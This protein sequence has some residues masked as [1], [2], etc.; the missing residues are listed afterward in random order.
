MKDANTLRQ[1]LIDT[2]RAFAPHGLG[3]G[4]SGN[5]SARVEGGFLITPSAMAY[6]QCIP[7]DIVFVDMSGGP[8]GTRKPSSEWL[9]HLAIYA[10]RK[11]VNAVVHTHAPACTALAC[12]HKKI[13]AFHYMVA[14]AGGSDIPCAPYATFGTQEL[15]DNVVEALQKRNACLLANHG[16][17]CLGDDLQQAFDLAIE[18]ES[19]AGIY[20]ETLKIGEPEFLSADDMQRVLEKFT[21]YKKTN[22]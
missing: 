14:I 22:V 4:S 15:A 2:A 5:V 1:Q 8:H 12:L 7:E 11:D 20:S 18:V 17:I 16:M 3:V 6:N 13:P 21:D 9:F 19:L 10:A